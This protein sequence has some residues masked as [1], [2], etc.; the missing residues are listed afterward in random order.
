[1]LE[2]WPPEDLYLVLVLPSLVQNPKQHFD[3]AAQHILLLSLLLIGLSIHI[4]STHLT[5]L[6]I[7]QHQRLPKIEVR[8][9]FYTFVLCY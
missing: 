3:Y 1:M 4:S 2:M 9:L 8:L 5:G 7:G 6:N